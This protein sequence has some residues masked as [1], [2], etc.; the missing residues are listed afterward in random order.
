MKTFSDHKNKPLRPVLRWVLF[1]AGFVAIALGV[2]GIFLPVLP[3]VP[4]LLLAL[5][6]FARS[7]ARFYN[8]LL[9]H[10]HLGP[11]V[12][13]YL[14]GRGVKHATKIKAIGLLWASIAISVLFLVNVIWVQ[15]ML[16][17]IGLGVS[18]YLLNLPT[19]NRQDQTDV[20]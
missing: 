1:I 12:G 2:V 8:W 13:P 11:L 16:L 17:V 6:C 10:A 19:S 9:D 7:S 5:A 15:G 18:L 3:T 14:Q 4:F 20:S